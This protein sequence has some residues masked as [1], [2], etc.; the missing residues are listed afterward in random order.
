MKYDLIIVGP[1]R[2]NRILR[3]G[4]LK[5]LLLEKSMPGGQAAMTERIENYRFSQGIG[6]PS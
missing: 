5:T 1:R 3:P 6:G 2:V 4:G